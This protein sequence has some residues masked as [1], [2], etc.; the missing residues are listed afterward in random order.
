[1]FGFSKKETYINSNWVTDVNDNYYK[2]GG[3]K[4]LATYLNLMKFI[5]FD[6]KTY[7][8]EQTYSTSVRSL[9]R[10]A[11]EHGRIMT[12]TEVTEMI[13]RLIKKGVISVISESNYERKH[14]KDLCPDKGLFIKDMDYNVSKN[15]IQTPLDVFEYMLNSGLNYRHIGQFILMHRWT[16]NS[17][18]KCYASVG[19]I[20]EYLSMSNTT[21]LKYYE[22]MNKIGVLAT[23]KRWNKNGHSYYEHY[24]LDSMDKFKEFQEAN[25]SALKKYKKDK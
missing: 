24:T 14:V 23:H 10:A 18:N 19:R 16:N 2:K 9:Y 25:K 21:V 3:H 15:Y 13:Q 22:D 4:L 5:R 20:A 17:E 6:Y 8:E 12:I 7:K 1:M 11:N